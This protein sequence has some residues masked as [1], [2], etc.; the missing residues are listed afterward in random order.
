[1][2]GSNRR[3]DQ[4]AF[5]CASVHG[6]RCNHTLQLDD[7]T[8]LSSQRAN[9]NIYRT[10]VIHKRSD[11]NTMLECANRK[12]VYKSCNPVE[13]TELRLLVLGCL[14]FRGLIKRDVKKSDRFEVELTVPVNLLLFVGASIRGAEDN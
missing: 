8:R 10:V 14:R 4:G 13:S 3:A 5:F 1:M 2:L 6:H 11:T 7:E 9:Y 12:I